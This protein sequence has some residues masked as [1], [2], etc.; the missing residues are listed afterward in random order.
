ASADAECMEVLIDHLHLLELRQATSTV[1]V[2]NPGIADVTMIATSQAVIT[3]RTVGATN[4]LF[5]DDLGRPIG[6]YQLFVREPEARRVVLHRGPAQTY[7][8][9]CAPNCQRTLSQTDEEG[10]HGALTKQIQNELDLSV[11]ATAATLSSGA[12]EGGEE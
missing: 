2:G 10:S 12:P 11:N 5:L 6:N 9:Q 1:L 8:Y 4:I 3:A 7:N